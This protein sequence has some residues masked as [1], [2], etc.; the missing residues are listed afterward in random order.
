MCEQLSLRSYYYYRDYLHI[1]AK[2][3]LVVSQNALPAQLAFT[4]IIWEM[5]VKIRF[6]APKESKRAF[7]QGLEAL[8]P[9][10]FFCRGQS[11]QQKFKSC[12]KMSRFCQF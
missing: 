5:I 9:P 8:S 12:Q 6:F 10:L 2:V 1:K 3:R 11:V 7:M 4:L